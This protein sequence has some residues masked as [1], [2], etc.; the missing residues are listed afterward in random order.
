[1]TK[2]R[3]AIYAIG[4]FAFY[5]LLACLCWFLT[6]IAN[7]PIYPWHYMQRFYLLQGSSA[8]CLLLLMIHRITQIKVLLSST[9]G[10]LVFGQI[11]GAWS[12]SVSP[13]HFN[14][15]WII[16]LVFWNASIIT[17]T[18]CELKGSKMSTSRWFSNRKMGTIVKSFICAFVLLSVVSSFVYGYKKFTF[19]RGAEQGY[20]YGLNSGLDDAT[21]GVPFCPNF[22][23]ASILSEYKIGSSA[24]NGFALYWPSGYSDGYKEGSDTDS[25]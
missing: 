14:E 21:N 19:N 16:V 20:I 6:D 4:V 25:Q 11:V 12:V 23:K 7:F 9:F 18:I 17:G 13:L 2:R 8:L 15:S 1:M 5:S 24:F 22:E 10:T 3:V